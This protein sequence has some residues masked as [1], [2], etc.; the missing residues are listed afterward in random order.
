MPRRLAQPRVGLRGGDGAAGG[1]RQKVKWGEGGGKEGG[2]A[3]RSPSQV[4]SGRV[5][6]PR[7]SP[8]A[9]R[10]PWRSG[11]GAEQGD[12]SAPWRAPGRG[13]S[14]PSPLPPE[15]PRSA[16]RA[17]AGHEPLDS[18]RRPR[19]SGGGGFSGAESGRLRSASRVRAPSERA[20]APRGRG[21]GGVRRPGGSGGL[22]GARLPGSAAGA[23]PPGPAASVLVCSVSEFAGVSAPASRRGRAARR[24]VAALGGSGSLPPRRGA[25]RVP[26]GPEQGGVRGS[27]PGSASG[28]RRSGYAL[29]ARDGGAGAVLGGSAHPS[30]GRRGGSAWGVPRV[31]APLSA[32]ASRPAPGE[33]ATSFAFQQ[34]ISAITFAP[35]SAARAPG[36]G[37]GSLLRWSW[38]LAAGC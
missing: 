38:L 29:G 6:S 35:I 27:G 16:A 1:W 26:L 22:S 4:R 5:G 37:R 12:P 33:A 30:A 28:L 24:Q 17:S 15:S 18:L 19:A 3:E 8:E 20:R 34:S 11:Y 10:S 31:S 9:S 23:R 32:S 2:R 14:G 25:S 13:P 7:T 36:P 21:G